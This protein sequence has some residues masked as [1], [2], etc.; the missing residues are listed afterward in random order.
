[1]ICLQFGNQK[2]RKLMRLWK[3]YR[4]KFFTISLIL[5]TLSL[6]LGLSLRHK[7]SAAHASGPDLGPQLYALAPD[8]H[9]I[10]AYDINSA[11]GW[12][13]IGGPAAHI[14]GGPYEA[15]SGYGLYATNPQTGDIYQYN[16]IPNSWTRIGGPGLNFVTGPSP[17]PGALYGQ[18]SGGIFAYT[19]QG[20]NWTQIGGPAGHLYGGNAICATD[21]HTGNIYQYNGGTPHSWSQIGGPGLDFACGGFGIYGQNSGGVFQYTGQGTN[22]TQIGGPAGHIY[23]GSEF[24]SV[25][26]T[27]IHTGDIYGYHSGGWSKIGG[28]GLDFVDLGQL[29]ST[30]TTDLIFGLNSGGIFMYTGGTSWTQIGGPAAEM[31][32]TYGGV[33]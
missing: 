6:S 33:G 27:D 12:I 4:V 30:S 8:H 9:A 11:T 3:S 7:P 18:N 10:F 25:L 1:M 29:S 16:G 15:G 22:W 28:P 2:G 23:A 19:G 13:Q 17:Y 26:A 5:L 14:Y 21:P 31:V 24:F 20:T 32:G